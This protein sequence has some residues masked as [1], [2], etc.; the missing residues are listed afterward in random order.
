M[1]RLVEL[2][3]VSR[4]TPP[5]GLRAY[6][7]LSERI[8]SVESDTGER[9][10]RLETKVDIVIDLMRQERE[11][12]NAAHREQHQTERARIGSRGKIIAA[13]ATAAG[14]IA[15]AIATI[16]AGGCS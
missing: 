2:H 10:V 11:D 8:D 13:L 12:R 14:V 7:E 6:N 16:I 1:G 9:L 3:T 5:F 4:N 15:G